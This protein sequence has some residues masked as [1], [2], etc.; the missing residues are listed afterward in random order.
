MIVETSTLR[1]REFA[2]ARGRRWRVWW[3]A[4]AHT[5]THSVGFSIWPPGIWFEA[6]KT[7]RRLF[8]FHPGTTS[9]DLERMPA[10]WLQQWLAR[11]DPFGSAPEGETPPRLANVRQ[12]RHVARDVA[13]AGT[14]NER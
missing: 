9:A 3:S 8:L 5:S 14:I 4:E 6:V 13:V 7:R 2:D 10:V 11:A 1:P 12:P